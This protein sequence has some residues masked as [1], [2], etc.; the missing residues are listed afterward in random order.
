M[1][2]ELVDGL[3]REGCPG[4]AACFTSR[5]NEMLRAAGNA[6]PDDVFTIGSVTKTF[7]AAAVLRLAQDGLLG[8]GE[9]GSTWC[10]L[11]P[12]D[13]TVRMLLDHTSRIPDYIGAPGVLEA[14]R[15]HPERVWEP[16]ELVLLVQGREPGWRYSNTNFVLLGLIL[17]A[18]T[19]QP[20]DE[21]LNRLVISPLGLTSTA[22]P[23]S[24]ERV[25]D[26]S[27]AWAAG[28]LESTPR[29]VARFPGALMRDELVD[30]TE[31]RRTVEVDDAEFD[32]YGAG[33]AV[34]SS[35]LRLADSACGSAWGHLGLGFRE[36]TL[37]LASSGGERCLIVCTRGALDESGW[38]TL[39]EGVWPIFCAGGL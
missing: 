12:R 17:E 13:V 37:A 24:G 36:S 26:P 30:T 29:E 23:R 18:A 15:E 28:A 3:V 8:L 35:I 25:P 27:F 4:V 21:V 19:A 39:R 11:V 31:L 32:R 22:L 38:R 20:L 5:G 14:V 9:P 33:I 34:M 16:R 7:V 1:L 6:E 2:G 10:D